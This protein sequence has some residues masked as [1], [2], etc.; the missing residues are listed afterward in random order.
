MIVGLIVVFFSLSVHEFCHGCTAYFFGDNTA[1]DAGRLTLNPLSHID[2]WGTI[3]MPLLLNFFIGIP[4][5]WAK[6]VPVNPAMLRNPKRD[7]MFVSIAGPLSNI[8]L[9]LVCVY[10]VKVNVLENFGFLKIFF[11]YGIMVNLAFAALNLIPI[12]PLDGA[13]VIMGLL[14]RA[15]AIAYSKIEPYGIIIVG[16]LI[17]FG[18]VNKWIKVFIKAVMSFIGV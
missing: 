1:K 12:P 18:I 2:L 9:A 5:G 6:P 10:L 11:Y 4:F 14:P 8:I 16:V 13:R 7:M 3:V 17:Y 15:Q